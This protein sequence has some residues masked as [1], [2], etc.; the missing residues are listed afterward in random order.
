MRKGEMRFNPAVRLYGCVKFFV[1]VGMK[2][3]FFFSVI[4][5]VNI[6]IVGDFFSLAADK[7]IRHTDTHELCDDTPIIYLLSQLKTTSIS[8]KKSINNV[9]RDS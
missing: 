9:R 3:S 7:T 4:Y 2:F 6:F 5:C 8:V 1:M